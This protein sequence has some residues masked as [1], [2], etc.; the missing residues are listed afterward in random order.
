MTTGREGGREGGN[1]GVVQVWEG[2]ELTSDTSAVY[3]DSSNTGALS[4]TSST[5]I[6]S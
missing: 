3:D 2:I 1:E 5:V 6:Y 4:F